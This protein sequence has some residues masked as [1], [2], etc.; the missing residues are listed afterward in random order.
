MTRLLLLGDPSP[1]DLHARAPYGADVLSEFGF[2][3]I[4]PRRSTRGPIRKLWDVVEHRTGVLIE[5]TIKGS[6]IRSD[7]VMGVLDNNARFSLCLHRAGIPPYRGRRIAAL[8]CWAAEDMAHMDEADRAK[9]VD[10]LNS[11]DILFVLS[12]NQVPILERFGVEQGKIVAVPFGVETDYFTPPEVG[13]QRS[14]IAAIGVDRGRDYHTLFRAVAGS[15]IAIDLYC[16]ERNLDGL[17]LPREV[18]WRGTVPRKEYREVLRRSAAVVVPT[19]ELAYPTGQSVALEAAASGACVVTTST[20]PMLEYFEPD[21]T[22]LM[23][24]PGDS[25]QLRRN[26]L[27][28]SD[29]EA[30]E[31]IATRGLN[32]CRQ[33]YTPQ[34]MWGAI[35]PWLSCTQSQGT[36]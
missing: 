2:D 33:Q 5:D 9:N 31:K 18:N 15:G 14:G 13:T 32:R 26:L 22:A 8:L 28:L 35:A 11:A 19:H 3:V 27:S 30:R 20:V 34:R 29:Q 17:E 36:A 21:V 6:F 16:G 1:G 24:P 23:S 7:A 4:N 25:E 10:L 12:R